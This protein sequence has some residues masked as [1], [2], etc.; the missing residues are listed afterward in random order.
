[1]NQT[2]RLFI[3]HQVKNRAMRTGDGSHAAYG[4]DEGRDEK[5]FKTAFG[6]WKHPWNPTFCSVHE[7]KPKN[8]QSKGYALVSEEMEDFEKDEAILEEANLKLLAEQNVGINKY[9]VDKAEAKA[10]YGKKLSKYYNDENNGEAKAESSEPSTSSSSSSNHSSD[11]ESSLDET[12]NNNL[13]LKK[14]KAQLDIPELPTGKIS[15]NHDLDSLR[16]R[17]MGKSS[18]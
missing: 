15:L 18:S 13:N 4:T 11:S 14:S 7:P 12:I 9:I 6:W 1:M 10:I 2:D 8:L 17:M 3:P 16:Q 5:N